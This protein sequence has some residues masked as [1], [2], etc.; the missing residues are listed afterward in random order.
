MNEMCD[1]TKLMGV[2]TKKESDVTMLEVRFE[3]HHEPL[4]WSSSDKHAAPC[5]WWFERSLSSWELQSPCTTKTNPDVTLC[6][7]HAVSLVSLGSF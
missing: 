2:L 1:S 6:D 7:M 4:A 5:I 3:V